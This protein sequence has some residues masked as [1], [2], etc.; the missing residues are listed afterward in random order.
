[1][2]AVIKKYILLLISI[3]ALL[4]KAT[5]LGNPKPNQQFTS[6]LKYVSA[7]IE[8]IPLTLI[9]YGILLDT[10]VETI[11]NL[12]LYSFIEEWTGTPYQYGGNEK[13][14]IDC[15]SFSVLLIREIYG[16]T[17]PRTSI[18]QYN[19]T[20]PVSDDDLCEGDLLFFK[21][22]EAPVSHVGV[23]LGNGKFVHASTGKGVT[24]D[25][26]DMNYYRNTYIGAGRVIQF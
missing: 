3:I 15:S 10:P 1:L 19:S 25:S 22:G 26:L 12:P 14:G 17:I 9:K 24:I 16:I 23:Y 8:E 7:S 5:A 6:E 11:T 4:N 2:Q 18:E 20:V 21:T 13:T